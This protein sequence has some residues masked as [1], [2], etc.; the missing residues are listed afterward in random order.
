MLVFR[1]TQKLA[2]K[3]KIAIPQTL[4]RADEPLAD[5]TANLFVADR[6]Q[7]ILIA[8]TATL[9]AAIFPGSGI[10]TPV[11]FINAAMAAII[12]QMERDGFRAIV[13]ERLIPVA[14]E[15]VFSKTGDRSVMGSLN[16][17]VHCA[18]AHIEYGR[19]SVETTSAKLGKTPLGALDD[20]YPRKAIAKL[21]EQ[22]LLPDNVIPFRRK[23]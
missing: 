10:K 5:W 18:R 22:P 7:Y 14:T 13:N 11:A 21:G 23:G 15:V 1:V 17:L 4:P 3:L 16:D 9:Y 2:T 19:D 6:R 12:A 8:N 20:V